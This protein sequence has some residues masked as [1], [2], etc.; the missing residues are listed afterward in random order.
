LGNGSNNYSLDPELNEDLAILE[1]E[2]PVGKQIVK[3][4][5]ADEYTGVVMKDGSCWVWGKNDRGQLGVGSGI[6][7]DMIESE[8]QPV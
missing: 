6:G 2:D 1:K 5:S 7:I 3:V 4:S 8:S